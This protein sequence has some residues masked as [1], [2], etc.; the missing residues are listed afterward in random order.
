MTSRRLLRQEWRVSLRKPFSAKETLKVFD[1]I[2]IEQ[3]LALTPFGYLSGEVL[4]M[5]K[6]TIA[7]GQ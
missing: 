1:A 3:K 2:I 6:P 5:Q 4:T 7:M